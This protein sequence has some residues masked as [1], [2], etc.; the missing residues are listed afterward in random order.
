M[1]RL[2]KGVCRLI[3]RLIQLV[4]TLFLMGVGLY[5]YVRYIE[6]RLLVVE[7]ESLDT[8]YFEAEGLRIVQFSDVHLGEYYSIQDL[9]KLVD[10]INKCSP[11]LVL[12]TGDL[13]DE[14][15]K[16]REGEQVGRLL[17]E[18]K[19]TYGKFAVYGNHDHGANGSKLYKQI[20]EEGGFT[21][22]KNNDVLITLPS[23]ERIRIMGIDDHSLGNPDIKS[24]VR[25]IK[26][27][28]Y[29]IFMS[30]APDCA[31]EVKAYPVDLQVAGH[32]HGGQVALP[33]LGPPFT[34]PYARKY[35]KGLYT[36]EAN[37][38]MTLYVNRGIG[39]SQLPYRLMNIP[40]VTLFLVGSK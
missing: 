6:P 21:L 29:N 20:I 4:L 7:K 1:S 25:Q 17:K 39:G 18:I 3:I 5:I 27:E 10:Q 8:H 14:G 16:Y 11:D 28:E 23:E 22:L 34:P 13:L 24:A 35:I 9:V 33:F 12:F 37:P 32:S 38:R 26:K 19:A 2:I 30:H 31:D 36:F 40:E 15:G